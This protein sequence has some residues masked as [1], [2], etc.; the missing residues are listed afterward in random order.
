[1]PYFHLHQLGLGFQ[2][3]RPVL[4]Q[5]ADPLQ[6]LLQEGD[7]MLLEEETVDVSGGGSNIVV[8][9]GDISHDFDVVG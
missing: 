7:L 6:R 4:V 9:I 2:R 8:E 3:Q 5:V 1:V